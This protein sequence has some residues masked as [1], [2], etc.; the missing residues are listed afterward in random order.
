MGGASAGQRTDVLILGGGPAG[1]AAARM[2]AQ[3]GHDVSLYA[4]PERAIAP[5]AESI[6]PSTQRILATLGLESAVSGAS[7]VRSTGNTVWWGDGA[8]RVE[9]FANGALGW[10][11]TS[12]RLARS[13]LAAAEDVGARVERRRATTE[14]VERLGPSITLD[15]TGRAGLFAR[16]KGWRVDEGGQ[17]IVALV[18]RWRATSWPL[19]DVSHTLIESY[20]GGWAWSVPDVSGDRHVAVMVDPRTSGLRRGSPARDVYRDEVAKTRQLSRLLADATLVDG[21]S[22]WDASMYH[23]RCFADDQVLLVGDAA[24]FIDPLSSIGIKKALV[25]GWLAAVATHTALARPRMRTVALEFYAAREAEMYASFRAMTHELLAQ[26]ASGH[27]GPFWAEHFEARGRAADKASDR[28]A[29]ARAFERIRTAPEI[30]LRA[31]P[32]VRLAEGPAVSGCEIVLEPRLVSDALPSGVRYEY[33]VDLIGL[34]TLAPGARQ[35]PDLYAEYC[36]RHAPVA[37]PDF[38]AALATAIA[39]GLLEWEVTLV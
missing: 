16:A 10:Q 14:Q 32:D 7:V 34:V 12:A 8:M 15:C 37:L 18:G 26:A 21:P 2:L 1:C 20:G 29:V 5:L 4:G 6:P 35:V 28:Q 9:P 22:G 13:L 33:D 38:L 39:Y 31:A 27:N 19:P 17:R 23:A 25:S 24:S 36:R 30:R 3:L 11:V